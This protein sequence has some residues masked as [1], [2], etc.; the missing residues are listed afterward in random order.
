MRM[1][2]YRDKSFYEIVENNPR[3][4]WLE[5]E[6]LALLLGR[7]DGKYEKFLTK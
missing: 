2:F 4:G 5:P 7:C 6:N 1:K 3:L